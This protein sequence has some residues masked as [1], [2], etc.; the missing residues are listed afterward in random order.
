MHVTKREY[1][2]ISNERNHFDCLVAGFGVVDRYEAGIYERAV[3]G[4][5]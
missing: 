3:Y 5:G 1:C 2:H 4:S